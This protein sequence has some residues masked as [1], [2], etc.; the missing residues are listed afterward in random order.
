MKKAA[1]AYSRTKQDKSGIIDPLK[2]HSYKYNDD[3]FKR[4]AITPDGKNHGMMM[5]IDWSGSM[6]TNIDDTIKQTI[7]LAMFCK[8]VQIPFRV[9]A[10]SDIKRNSFFNKDLDEE[11][12][13]SSRANKS[14]DRSPFVHKQGDLFVENVNLVEWLSSFLL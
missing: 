3:I 5:F 8:A 12:G 6:S 2:L 14:L 1:A 13:W 10:F 4:M 9:F 11:Y 7:N